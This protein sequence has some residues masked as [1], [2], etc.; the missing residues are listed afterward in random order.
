MGE[1]PVITISGPNSK[2]N[3][4]LKLRYRCQ[5]QPDGTAICPNI[6]ESSQASSSKGQKSG[7]GASSSGTS[8]QAEGTGKQACS[9]TCFNPDD[10]D[11]NSDCL[12]ASKRG[13]RNDMI[14]LRS[15]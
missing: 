3:K 14:L 8:T 7:A 11:I 12:C 13:N 10:C 6:D 2:F 15:C 9:G 1:V 4:A 5:K